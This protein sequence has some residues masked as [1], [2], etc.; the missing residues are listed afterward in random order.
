[1][2]LPYYKS[3]IFICAIIVLS[4]IRSTGGYEVFTYDDPDGL[5]ELWTDL[6]FSD[7]TIILNFIKRTNDTCMEP[8][9]YYRIIH[10]NGTIVPLTITIP[11]VE[12]FNFCLETHKTHFNTHTLTPDYF[13]ITYLVSQPNG[14]KT[15][16]Q[17]VGNL[18]DL[19]GR[20]VNR[21]NLTEEIDTR[22]EF[23]ITKNIN[24]EDGFIVTK[25]TGNSSQYDQEWVTYKAP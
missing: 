3:I 20:I 18:V 8:S 15:Y 7:G 1:M 16:Y 21:V 25:V 4:L 23:G 12:Q 13:L 19:H 24:P 9:F 2:R 14:N 6:S 10:L 17:R 11:G 22:T 5:W